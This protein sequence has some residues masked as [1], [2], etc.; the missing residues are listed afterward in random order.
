MGGPH[1]NKKTTKKSQGKFFWSDGQTVGQGQSQG[2]FFWSDGRTADSGRMEV[3]TSLQNRPN[4]SAFGWRNE[5]MSQSKLN[6]L[7]ERREKIISQKSRAGS[8][9]QIQRVVDNIL[10]ILP[11]TFIYSSLR[12]FGCVSHPLLFI[13]RQSPIYFIFG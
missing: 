7:T 4:L 12:F 5:D 1:L 11:F 3:F 2:K 10:I 8:K 6:F 13:Y 9:C